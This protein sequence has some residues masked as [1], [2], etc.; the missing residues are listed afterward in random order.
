MPLAARLSLVAKF[1]RIGDWKP[2]RPLAAAANCAPA[3]S[4][5]RLSSSNRDARPPDDEQ[6]ADD[7]L[8]VLLVPDGGSSADDWMLV[9]LVGESMI[10]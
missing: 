7:W 4:E 8:L 10:E 6:S 9:P 5:A 1:A 3:I 2:P